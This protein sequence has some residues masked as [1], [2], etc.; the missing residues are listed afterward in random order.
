MDDNEIEESGRRMIRSPGNMASDC[1][2]SSPGS[3]EIE[4]QMS[5]QQM[6][7][8]GGSQA[9]RQGNAQG[10]RQGA[11]QGRKGESPGMTVP[12]SIVNNDGSPVRM[13][14]NMNMNMRMNRMSQQGRMGP[15]MMHGS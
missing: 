4:I 13:R 8:V 10:A 1:H 2:R 7:P 12:V 15:A 5:R 9:T 11:R 3:G 6:S 14:I